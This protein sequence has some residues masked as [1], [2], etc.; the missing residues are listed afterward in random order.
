M[1]MTRMQ[2][3]MAKL[4]AQHAAGRLHR[5]HR[6][7]LQRW[8]EPVRKAFKEMRTG[9]ML[10]VKGYPV[11]SL[12]TG[13]DLAR[14]DH[15]INGFV[16][17]IERLDTGLDIS[18]LRKV[19]TKLENGVLLTVQEIDACFALLNASET[20]LLRFSRG[21]LADVAKIEQINIEFERMGLK[22]AA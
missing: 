22:E 1:A 18:P 5:P 12:H 6:A 9:E 19:S 16:A 17:M 10:A 13:D 8:L 4:Q 2:L 7:R 11:T 14:I 3:K 20:A 21:H 15:C